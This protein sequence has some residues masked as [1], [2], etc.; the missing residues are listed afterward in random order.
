MIQNTLAK[1]VCPDYTHSSDALSFLHWL[2][3]R[4]RIHSKIAT[5]TFKL[6][7]FGSPTYLSCLLKPYLSLETIT[8]TFTDILSWKN[9]NKL[10]LNPSKTEFLLIIISYIYFINTSDKPHRLTYKKII[11][12]TLRV[13]ELMLENKQGDIK[14]SRRYISFYETSSLGN[15]S[16]V[17]SFVSM[18]AGNHGLEHAYCKYETVS[19]GGKAVEDGYRH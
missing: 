13:I 6:L 4:Q 2:P 8:I 18:G 12:I 9:L 1:L 7:N 10:L 3:V 15:F 19:A 14:I 5:L 16:R 11:I 17:R